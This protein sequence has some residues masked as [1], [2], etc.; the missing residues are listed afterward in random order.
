MLKNIWMKTKKI[1]PFLL[2]GA[3]FSGFVLAKPVQ[4]TG[5]EFNIFPNDVKT[6]RV[7]NSSQN[8]D[9]Q[10][11]VSAANGETVSFIV[12]YHNGILNTVAENTVVKVDLPTGPA[13]TFQPEVSISA[14]NTAATITDTVTINASQA[15]NLAYIPDTTKIFRD[16]SQTAENLPDG[17][18]SASGI[19]IGNI[20]GCWDY[21]GYITFQ[22]NLTAPELPKEGKLNIEKM[23]SNSTRDQGSQNW[24]KQTTAGEGEFVAFRLFITNPGEATLSEVNVKDILPTGLEYA[25][26]TTNLTRDGTTST[27]PDGIVGNGVTINDLKTGVNNGVYVIFQA[28]VKISGDATLINTARATSGEL[29]TQDTATVI[30]AAT[31]TA[32]PTLTKNVRNVSRN[33]SQFL[34]STTASNG[35]VVEFK[36]N[37]KNI[38]DLP[39]TNL[40]LVDFL[41]TGLTFLGDPSIIVNT[42]N[43]LTKLSWHFDQINPGDTETI[44]FQARVGN[45]GPG[46][47][48][49]TNEADLH[50]AC[51]DVLKAYAKVYIHNEVPSYELNKEVLNVTKGDGIWLTNN[52]AKASDILE[53]RIKFQ[54]TGNVTQ[55]V[56]I[57]DNL[58]AVV[59]YIAQS[60]KV[61]INGQ[62]KPFSTDL[63]N[64]KGLNF[65]LNPGDT[66]E[67]HFRVKV[68]T[69]IAC[70]SGFENVAFLI[71]PSITIKSSVITQIKCE[72]VIPKPENLPATGVADILPFSM[73]FG[74]VNYGLF[75]RTRRKITK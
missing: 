1:V 68:M 69:S 73:L 3:L 12:Y 27:L 74:L 16:G 26:G 7:A 13:S 49:L 35:E 39:I 58:P 63:F 9:W 71:S 53:Y 64:T 67:I 38:G 70:A 75:V 41:P 30:V 42:N 29:S 4:S 10:N 14:D 59:N 65:I 52:Q 37:A 25:A 22:A 32:I 17:I 28:R 51:C 45:F 6:F 33:E 46:D 36:M 60:G 19:N 55:N 20:Q 31:H 24:Q 34:D 11:A 48:T 61:K 50:T 56:K 21:A 43:D 18:V 15:L 5:P 40:N 44:T 23:V 62:V 72:K 2:L 54:N 66:G 47:T 57:T 8:T